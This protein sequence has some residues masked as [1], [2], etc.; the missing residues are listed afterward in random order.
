MEVSV[1]SSSP[2]GALKKSYITVKNADMYM[3]AYLHNSVEISTLFFEKGS[4]PLK[5]KSIISPVKSFQ[6]F[7]AISACSNPSYL[8]SIDLWAHA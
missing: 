1:S 4:F 2:K 6:P 8:K 3:R 5:P 7:E